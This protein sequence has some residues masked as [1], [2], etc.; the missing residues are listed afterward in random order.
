GWILAVG[1]LAV[2]VSL[3]GWLSDARKEYNRT[4]RA[5]QTGHLETGPAPG[6][7]KVLVPLFAFLVVAA[8]AINAGWFPPRSAVGG[9]GG[10]VP[11]APVGGG[12]PRGVHS[13]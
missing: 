8:V 2:I 11:A 1:L 12:G 4:V 7:P 10:S 6:W 5:D 9:S 13:R 3:L